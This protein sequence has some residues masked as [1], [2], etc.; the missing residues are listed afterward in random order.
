MGPSNNAESRS[1]LFDVDF[2]YD[3]R[4]INISKKYGIKGELATVKLLCAINRNGAFAIWDERLKRELQRELEGASKGML[5]QIVNSLVKQGFFDKIPFDS[6][7]ILTS[8]SIQN[9]YFKAI[10]DRKLTQPPP[11]PSRNLEYFNAQNKEK[12]NKEH[13]GE[14]EEKI[15]SVLPP[16]PPIV[17]NNYNISSSSSSNAREKKNFLVIEEKISEQEKIFKK[18]SENRIWVERTCMTHRINPE[19]IPVLLEELNNHLIISGAIDDV[20][21]EKDAQRIFTYW[22]PKRQSRQIE[23]EKRTS[24]ANETKED[25]FSTRRG[26]EPGAKSRQDYKGAF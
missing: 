1:F 13:F 18:L 20:K 4:I 8:E 9:G 5:E 15:A 22:Y 7:K 10:S 24:K 11:C 14:N 21:E 12:C 25:R 19:D 16:Y 6:A 26:T 23:N 2:F 3:A 17:Y